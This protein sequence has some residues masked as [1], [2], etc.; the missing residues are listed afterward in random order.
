MEAECNQSNTA[1]HIYK[2]VELLYMTRLII[3]RTTL[4]LTNKAHQ[5][6]IP[7]PY[8]ND[9]WMLLWVV[10]KC[11]S[12][13]LWLVKMSFEWISHTH[14]TPWTIPFQ[15]RSDGF[16]FMLFPHH[17]LFVLN[18]FILSIMFQAHSYSPASQFL[19]QKPLCGY[20][21]FSTHTCCLA[22]WFKWKPSSAAPVR[23]TVRASTRRKT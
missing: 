2:A 23:A 19:Q 20:S 11:F 8:G 5:V 16:S 21:W 1:Q 15:T 10:A 6:S 12:R 4:A 22:V 18:I 17:G 3:S 14:K 9:G 13:K 7:K